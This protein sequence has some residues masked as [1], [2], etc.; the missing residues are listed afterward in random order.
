MAFPLLMMIYLEGLER[1]LK[2]KTVISIKIREWGCA[3]WED[4]KGK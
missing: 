4:K 2:S 1:A 3:L